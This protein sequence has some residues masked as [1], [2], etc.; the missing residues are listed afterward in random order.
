M[1]NSWTKPVIRLQP[2]C[3]SWT[4][5]SLHVVDAAWDVSHEVVAEVELPQSGQ[6][7]ERGRQRGQLVV[8][9]T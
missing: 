3:L 7:A 8:G 5:Q 4:Y 1:T 2:V 6:V 9:Q